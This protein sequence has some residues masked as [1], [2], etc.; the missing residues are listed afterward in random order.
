MQKY[1]F[2]NKFIDKDVDIF[3]AGEEWWVLL[4]LLQLSNGDDQQVSKDLFIGPKSEHCPAL[5]LNKSLI[6]SSWWDLNDLT[7]VCE[8]SRNLQKSRNIFLPYFTES[9]Q[10]TQVV[11]ALSKFQS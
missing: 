1:P 11:E 8:D 9:C 2:H 6:P 7:L 10:T 4:R 5:S 3:A